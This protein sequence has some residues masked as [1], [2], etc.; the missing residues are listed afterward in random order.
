MFHDK[1]QS[2]LSFPGCR[3]SLSRL[4]NDSSNEADKFAIEVLA[5]AFLFLLPVE[6]SD[7]LFFDPAEFLSNTASA[8]LLSFPFLGTSI[9]KSYFFD[10]S[11]IDL[12]C[13]I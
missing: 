4:E 13:F 12:S 3:T 6:A 2:V 8:I 5:K 9:S 11:W 10:G 7:L 1:I